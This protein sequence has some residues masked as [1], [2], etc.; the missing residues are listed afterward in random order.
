[1]QI[2]FDMVNELRMGAASQSMGNAS[3]SQ[4]DAPITPI[5]TQ[6]WVTK[7]CAVRAAAAAAAELCCVLKGHEM[8]AIQSARTITAML[9]VVPNEIPLEAA[10]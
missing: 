10:M 8:I 3:Q 1:M 7:V 9:N 5:A 4:L 2:P 6:K